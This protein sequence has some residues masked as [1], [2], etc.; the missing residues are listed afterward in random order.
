M[1]IVLVNFNKDREY[2]MQYVTFF[3]LETREIVYAVLTTGEAGGS[4]MGGHWADG[5][6]DGVRKVFVDEVY[7]ER[8]YNNGMIHSNLRLY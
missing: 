5:V 3:D 7:K 6:I 1:V 4:G 2:S 8:A